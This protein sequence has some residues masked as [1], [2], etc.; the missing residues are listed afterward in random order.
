[1][2]PVLRALQKIYMQLKLRDQI[3]ELIAADLNAKVEKIGF[4]YW[5][6]LV[7]DAVNLGTIARQLKTFPQRCHCCT[8][9]KVHLKNYWKN[10]TTK[11]GYVVVCPEILGTTLR[12]GTGKESLGVV[13]NWIDKNIKTEKNKIIL[14]GS[15][16]GGVGAFFAA[17]AFPDRFSL[18]I[19]MPG[20]YFSRTGT[21]EKL[22]GKSVW[23]LVGENDAQWVQLAKRTEQ[24][25]KKAGA[26]PELEILEKQGHVLQIDSKKRFFVEFSGYQV[27]DCS[28]MGLVLGEWGDEYSLKSLCVVARSR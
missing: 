19:S 22:K 10:E 13:L 1:M 18:I 7:L 5:T 2:I 8:M 9:V 24:L 27:F 3:L 28:G 25:L 14:T 21:L 4:I 23:L 6:I 26:K 11:K 17:T 16:N 12:G 20:G 15:S